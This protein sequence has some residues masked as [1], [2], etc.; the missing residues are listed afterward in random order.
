MVLPP[1]C[2]I[3]CPALTVILLFRARQMLSANLLLDWHK[4]VKI[5]GGDEG[6]KKKNI[7]KGCRFLADVLVLFGWECVCTCVCVCVWV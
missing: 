3:S 7:T 5:D 1:S 4:I 2:D 6:K